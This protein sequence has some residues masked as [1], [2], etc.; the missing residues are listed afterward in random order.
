MTGRSIFTP[1]GKL[2]AAKGFRLNAELM[3][4]VNK[5]VAE[6]SVSTGLRCSP[7]DVLRALLNATNRLTKSGLDDCLF[8][9]LPAEESSVPC[10]FTFRMTEEQLAFLNQQAVRRAVKIGEPVKIADVLRAV[11]RLVA[12]GRLTS[13]DLFTVREH[14]T[15]N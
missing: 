9:S 1:V 6:V 2:T 8:D 5:I 11:I 13:R 15:A 10:T 12:T 4:I 7:S 14:N 3:E